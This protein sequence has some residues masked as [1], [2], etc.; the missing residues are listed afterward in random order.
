MTP[1]GRVVGVLPPASESQEKPW[2]IG[3]PRASA[4][5]ISVS[6]IGS[7]RASALQIT[8]PR[9]VLLEVLYCI[10][11][12]ASPVFPFLG[13]DVVRRPFDAEA[14]PTFSKI[15]NP[16]CRWATTPGEQAGMQ[17]RPDAGI[18]GLGVIL[19]NSVNNEK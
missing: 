17:A 12:D 4:P 1:A 7:P 8:V 5:E 14:L 10:H 6:G 16:S 15:I 9:C 19:F 11:R 13:T 18:G 2:G 3:S